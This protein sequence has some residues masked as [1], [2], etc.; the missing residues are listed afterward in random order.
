MI[1]IDAETES[2]ETP[3]ITSILTTQERRYELKAIF[4]GMMAA[5]AGDTKR[6]C[7]SPVLEAY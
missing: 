4:L 3:S 6:E 2:I 1:I 5:I 7:D